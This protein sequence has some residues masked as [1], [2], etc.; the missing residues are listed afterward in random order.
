MHM[1][2]PDEELARAAAAGDREAFAAL[3]ARHYDRLF[4][5]AF[6]LTGAAAE[7]E[8][9]TQD[10]CLALPGKLGGFRGE[11]RFTSWLY[12][13]ALNAAQDRRRR[14]ASRDRAALGW[15]ER[16]IARRAE[17]DAAA[18]DHGWLAAAMRALPEELRDTLALIL[19]DEMTHAEAAGVLGLSEGTV[20]WR[21]SE[22][23][24]RLRALR[25][26]ELEE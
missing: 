18:E 22:A 15:G 8:D 16:E 23:R 20:S 2:V 6:R 3:L 21:L 1:D 24:K 4:R 19:D 14:Q 7:A 25:E 13:V 17:A 12:R 11:A 9:L 10:I 5:L 26:E